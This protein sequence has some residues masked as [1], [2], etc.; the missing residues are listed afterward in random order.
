MESLWLLV[1]WLGAAIVPSAV[2]GI[3]GNRANDG[4]EGWRCD[5]DVVAEGR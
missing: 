5:G 2:T 3:I 1:N 4:Y